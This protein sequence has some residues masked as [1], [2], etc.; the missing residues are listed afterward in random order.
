MKVKI[1]QSFHVYGDAK[2]D[3]KGVM[4]SGPK[5][6]FAAGW[7]KDVDDAVAQGWIKNGLAEEVVEQPMEQPTLA[8][9]AAV[10]DH[11]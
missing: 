11:H 6:D 10:E 2:P 9:A 1:L 7:T 8:A 5:E 3:E 4:R